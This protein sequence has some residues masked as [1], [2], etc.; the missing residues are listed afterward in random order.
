MTPDMLLVFAILGVA[1]ALFASDWLRLD[2]VALL[3]L[4]EYVHRAALAEIAGQR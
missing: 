1:M 3:A 4:L 2:L